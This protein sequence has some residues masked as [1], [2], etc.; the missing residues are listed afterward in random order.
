MAMAMGQRDELTEEQVEK[1]N[2]TIYEKGKPYLWVKGFGWGI[3]GFYI[4]HLS[5]LFIRVAHCNHFRNAGKDYGRLAIEGAG[6]E[7]EWR[8]EGNAEI[9]VMAIQRVVEYHGKVPRSQK[10]GGN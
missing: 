9:N 8:Y 5:P 2:K 1:F 6:D 7:C 3:V 4:D 10:P